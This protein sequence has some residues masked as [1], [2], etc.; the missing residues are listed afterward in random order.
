MLSPVDIAKTSAMCTNRIKFP[1][2]D[3]CVRVFALFRGETSRRYEFF[4]DRI[5]KALF[6]RY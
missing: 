2:G 6:F 1:L 3:F 4:D 5:E